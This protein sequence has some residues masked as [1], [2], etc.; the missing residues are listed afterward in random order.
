MK[1][2][3]GKLEILRLGSD[4]YNFGLRID[5]IVWLCYEG[6]QILSWKSPALTLGAGVALT[7]VIMNLK[8][9]I[10]IAAACLVFGKNA[11]LKR[12]QQINKKKDIRKRLLIPRENYVF[13]QTCM[14]T[15]NELFEKVH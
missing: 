13:L 10:F 11:L 12:I 15:Y 8:I 5:P 1:D 4:A 7:F 9:A 2:Q 14:K 3:A 6:Q